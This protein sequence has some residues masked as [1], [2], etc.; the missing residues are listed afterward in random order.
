MY[1]NI[2]T[3]F[4][5]TIVITLLWTVIC[6]YIEQ[7]WFQSLV[8]YVPP[9]IAIIIILCLA[10]FPGIMICLTITGILLDKPRRKE[11]QYNE[12]EEITI[13][14][15]AYN[16]EEGIYDT[17][18]SISKQDYPQVI[19]VYVI[20]NN[21]KDNTK[22]E[23]LRA[24]KDFTNINIQYYLETTQGK[25]A[26]L[27]QGLFKTNT[28]FVLT[29]DADTY[30]Y[31]D[32]LVHIVNTMVQESKNKKVG[33]VAGTVL[34]RNSRANLL[35]AM[36]EWEYFLSIAAIKR[37][38][39]LFQSVLVAQGAFSIYD[40]KLIQE[41]GG[42]KDSIGEDIVLTWNILSKGYKTYY[43]DL[44]IS[45]TNVPTKLKIFLR[46]RSR[47]AR[48]MIEGFRHVKF[49]DIENKYAKIF[50]FCD[51]F[52]FFIDFGVCFFYIPG[53]I[54]ALLCHIWLIVGPM[55]LLLLPFTFIFFFIMLSIEYCKVFKYMGLKIRKHYLALLV[56][57]L[58]YSIL[59]SPACIKGYLQEIFG[60][61]RKWK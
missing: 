24:Q 20:D 41:L 46:Q 18:Q 5:I 38:Q 53:I 25:F 17:L 57:I 12:L 45:F 37:M 4:I 43:E 55:I 31:K 49:K 27:N 23:I 7:F 22:Q 15:A 52:L 28:R 40:T 14:I 32:A 29:I 19:N 59:L 56:F 11:I 58:T 34:V 10:F 21:S 33:A 6:C 9:F 16:E 13:L 61:K 2:K 30:L 44:A 3:K 8:E 47:W 42:W 26:A 35:A 51:Y 1:L 50:I 39:G 48:G 54:L 36:Q 60:T